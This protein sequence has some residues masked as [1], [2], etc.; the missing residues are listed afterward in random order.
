MSE[1][2]AATVIAEADAMSGQ[3][4][5]DCGA[6]IHALEG[7]VGMFLGSRGTPR[8]LDCL[9]RL[10]GRSPGELARSSAEQMARLD[11]YRAGWDHA[12]ARL[13]G[14]GRWP[15]PRFETLG[16]SAHAAGGAAVPA[17]GALAPL[18]ADDCWD[19]GET[20]C[21]DLA[22]E[23][24]IRLQG[25]RAGAVLRLRSTDPGAIGDV[26]AWC[27]VTGHALLRAAPPDYYIR[28]RERDGPS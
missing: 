27:R 12:R 23:L 8:C 11:C 17:S 14:E 22:L 26:P 1:I 2:R 18:P 5:R 13:E 25:M 6:E 20:S 16:A 19:A 4:C 28:R 10:Y 15:P 3:A 21:G 7:A 24:R 9:A